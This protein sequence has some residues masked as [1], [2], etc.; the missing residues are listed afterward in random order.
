MMYFDKGFPRSRFIRNF[1][2]EDEHLEKEGKSIESLGRQENQQAFTS[3]HESSTAFIGFMG[4]NPRLYNK[5][6]LLP[7][8]L[9]AVWGE[10][11]QKTRGSNGGFCQHLEIPV[12]CPS[13]SL[14]TEKRHLSH[15]SY[16]LGTQSFCH[17]GQLT[18]SGL[19]HLFFSMPS[20]SPLPQG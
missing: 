7:I 1:L 20:L 10:S 18:Q 6:D 15:N 14:A 12:R 19:P 9:V 3:L 8:I 11:G 4:G 17:H 5:Q 2:M 13:K 16:S